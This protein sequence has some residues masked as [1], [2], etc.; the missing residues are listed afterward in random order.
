MVPCRRSVL[1]IYENGPVLIG[2]NRRLRQ[3]LII[4]PA[5]QRFNRSRLSCDWGAIRS[6]ELCLHLYSVNG[7]IP[8][9]VQNPA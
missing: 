6:D 8:C 3:V 7:G 1:E 5:K 2:L 4:G 9:I